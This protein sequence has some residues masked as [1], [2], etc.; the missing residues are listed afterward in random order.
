MHS[1]KQTDF[2]LE[3]VLS[4]GSSSS[5]QYARSVVANFE[6][7]EKITL[8]SDDAD[9]WA[10]GEIPFGFIIDGSAPEGTLARLKLSWLNR[11]CLIIGPTGVGKSNLGRILASGL[12]EHVPIMIFDRTG[13][14]IGVNPDRLTVFPI[15]HLR[16]NPNEE[17]KG[18]PYD[19]WLEIYSSVFIHSLILTDVSRGSFV[20]LARYA[21]ERFKPDDE[22][23]RTSV[24]EQRIALKELKPKSFR[25]NARMA[26][27]SRLEDRYDNIITSAL[28]DVFACYK[29]HDLI[30]LLN[31]NIVFDCK[32]VS[33]HFLRIL[34]PLI[35]AKIYCYRL[36]NDQGSRPLHAVMIEEAEDIFGIRDQ[37][38]LL[39]NPIDDMVRRVR[40]RGEFLIGLNQT[41]TT[42]SR[43]LRSNVYVQF[44]LGATNAAERTEIGRSIGLSQEQWKDA[45]SLDTPRAFVSIEGKKPLL[46]S[47]PEY[48]V[49]QNASKKAN[50]LS[51]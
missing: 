48:K 17:P 51:G 10:E 33:S 8:H 19:D 4:A 27:W 7:C 35:I 9:E 25:D 12:M 28:G 18:V 26:Y 32:G 23:L 15:R 46:V 14:H 30:G 42:L 16:L 5:H 31:E 43:A 49:K 21:N 1:Q 50:L 24:Y 13:D 20:Q 47:I 3:K 39:E 41:Y 22:S 38:G 40:G 34:V 45:L 37:G 36:Y 29:G 6:R 11:H 2:G 44:M